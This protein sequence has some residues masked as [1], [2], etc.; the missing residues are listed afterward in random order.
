MRDSGKR[1]TI[2]SHI[3]A[4]GLYNFIRGVGWAYKRGGG[5]GLI[6]GGDI[7]GIKNVSERRDKTRTC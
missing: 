2:K 1:N 4:L 3:K 6:L 7:S 5:G